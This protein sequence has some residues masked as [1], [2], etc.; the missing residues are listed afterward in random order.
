MKAKFR[1]S[2]V[3]DQSFLCVSNMPTEH[4]FLLPQSK[5]LVVFETTPRMS[6]YVRSNHALFTE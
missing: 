2:A 3:V 5:K 4:T 6:T 1:M